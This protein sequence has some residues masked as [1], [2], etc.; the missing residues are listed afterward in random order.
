MMALPISLT[1]D[2][3]KAAECSQLV[4]VKHWESVKEEGVNFVKGKYA[5]WEEQSGEET[6]NGK[7]FH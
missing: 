2:K 6:Q 7:T 5:Q 3:A 1:L 4:K